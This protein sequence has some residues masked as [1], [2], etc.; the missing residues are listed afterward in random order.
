MGYRVD[1]LIKN[2]ELAGTDEELSG[3]I[4]T[5]RQI[6][7]RLYDDYEPCPY[8]TFKNRLDNWVGNVDQVA[9]QQ[10]LVR[11][12]GRIFFIGRREYDSLYR[13]IFLGP[14]ARWLIDQEGISLDDPAAATKLQKAVEATWFCPLT[15]SMRINA[16][17]KVNNIDGQQYRPE[18]RSLSC[19]GDIGKIKDFTDRK[20]LKRLILIEDFVGSGN[21]TKPSIEFATSVDPNISVLACPLV[22]CREGIETLEG[23]KTTHMNLDYAAGLV[24]PEGCFVRYTAPVPPAVEEKSNPQ[25]RTFV[26]SVARRVKPATGDETHGYD[27]MGGLVVLY[28]NCPNNSLPL[29]HRET[30]SWSPLFPRIRRR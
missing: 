13:S 1:A 4:R 19:F 11:L 23:L 29:I 30:D 10:T 15:D 18:W 28:S 7:P 17:L 9:D 5:L 3:A 22:V 2:W 24:L 27:G 14:I 16:F 21:Q 12:L 26:A 25:V 6:A 20:K 8:D